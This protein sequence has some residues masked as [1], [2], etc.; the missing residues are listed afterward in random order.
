MFMRTI[1]FFLLA[2]FLIFCRKTNAAIPGDSLKIITYNIEGMKPGTDADIR[3]VH[4]IAELKK[5]NPDIIALQEIN[6]KSDGSHNQGKMIAD[7]L[8]AYFH[9]P[10]YF[11]QTYEHLAWDNQFREL[12]GIISKY[13]VKESGHKQLSKGIFY[14]QVIWNYIETPLGMIN[15]FATHLSFNSRIVRV[16]Q[17]QEIKQYIAKID[18]KYPTIA[19]IL[20]G[21][22]NDVFDSEPIMI[23]TNKQAVTFFIDSF[24][25]VNSVD[26]GNTVPASLPDSKIDYI[27]YG[28]TENIKTISSQIIMDKPY[29]KGNYNSDHFGVMTLFYK[30]LQH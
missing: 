4:I 9:I 7:S 15:L 14:R 25:E 19:T 22:F 27:F 28:N 11:Y 6:E 17:V 1:S 10:Y 24:A 5:L 2:L 12:I 16:K 18:D 30:S 21:D 23:L 29:G 3:I 26:S 8:S 13:S 20:A